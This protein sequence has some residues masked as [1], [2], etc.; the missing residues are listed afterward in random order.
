MVIERAAR[1]VEPAG[2]PALPTL[3]RVRVL[4]GTATLLLGQFRSHAKRVRAHA[5]AFRRETYRL[6]AASGADLIRIDQGLDGIATRITAALNAVDM[7]VVATFA[8][9][10]TLEHMAATVDLEHPEHSPAQRIAA[11]AEEL[12]A[13]LRARHEDAHAALRDVVEQLVVN[14]NNLAIIV[15]QPSAQSIQQL[16]VMIR[17]MRALSLI[18]A[19]IS[20]RLDVFVQNQS[21]ALRELAPRDLAGDSAWLP[22]HVRDAHGAAPQQEGAA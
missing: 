4:E 15:G 20:A 21:A 6:P 9:I 19:D 7:A 5:A 2:A 22:S 3:A 18:T 10:A 17:Q 8:G 11:R 14:A 16:R 12:L 13:G 1:P